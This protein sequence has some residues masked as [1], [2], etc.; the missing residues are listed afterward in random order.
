MAA[1]LALRKSLF[2]L[3]GSSR[4]LTRPNLHPFIRR[5]SDNKGKPALLFAKSSEESKLS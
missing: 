1:C 4:Q 2:L 3:A 5:Y